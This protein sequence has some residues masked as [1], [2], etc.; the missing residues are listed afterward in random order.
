M[1]ENPHELAATGSGALPGDR[2]GDTCKNQCSVEELEKRKQKHLS[3]KHGR[4][5][6]RSDLANEL[7]KWSFFRCRSSDGSKC[8][9]SG[10]GVREVHC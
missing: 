7:Q 6:E 2:L 3:S 8:S 4:I 10:D 1:E 9:T 5:V